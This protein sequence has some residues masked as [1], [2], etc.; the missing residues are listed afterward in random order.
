MAGPEE[1]R[2]TIC[3]VE[4]PQ[5][6]EIFYYTEFGVNPVPDKLFEVFNIYYANNISK[7]S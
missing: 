5:R 6:S 4:N 7:L 2:D 3:N 1:D